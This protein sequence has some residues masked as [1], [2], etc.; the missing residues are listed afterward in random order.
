MERRTTVSVFL[1]ATLGAVAATAAARAQ[2]APRALCF[3]KGFEAEAEPEAMHHAV[4][5]EV[6]CAH[7]DR[8][9]VD[10]TALDLEL[11]DGDEDLVAAGVRWM[12]EYS[13][14][15]PDGG[16]FSSEATNDI[17]VSETGRE[18]TIELR[19]HSHALPTGG[20]AR[21]EGTVDL[22]VEA[23]CVGESA[24]E[25]LTVETTAGALR[26]GAAIPL[27]AG[28]EIVASEQGTSNDA[29][30]LVLGGGGS[31][32]ALVEPPAGVEEQLF[33][34]KKLLVVGTDVADETP[35][36][37]RVCPTEVLRVPVDI[38]AAV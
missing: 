35:V 18:R 26:S 15:H 36:T 21:L 3:L 7:A 24:T 31:Y 30:M 25:P 38:E 4:T 8:R 33:F 37:L 28:G 10:A 34:G 14:T 1:L 11:L 27:A 16:F 20:V 32:V 29:P 17:V 2:E 23:D 12:E 19:A 9:V 5:M 13:A 22:V 6:T